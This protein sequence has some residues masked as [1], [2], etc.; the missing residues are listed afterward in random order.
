[1][2]E[3]CKSKVF[4]IVRAN[5][6]NK[7]EDLVFWRSI[8]LPRLAYLLLHIIKHNGNVSLIQSRYRNPVTFQTKCL[9]TK[10][11]SFQHLT[12]VWKS[13]ILDLVGFLHWTQCYSSLIY[14]S[15]IF[16]LE[17]MK[18][19]RKWNISWHKQKTMGIIKYYAQL[20]IWRSRII[21]I[22]SFIVIY[23]NAIEKNKTTWKI[24]AFSQHM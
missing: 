16:V 3:S 21:I 18:H 14:I 22:C 17:K 2:S 10:D 9:A 5:S 12:V 6:K 11:V 13:S 19:F 4:T 1:M 15:N 24:R 8:M 23:S 7:A 20:Q